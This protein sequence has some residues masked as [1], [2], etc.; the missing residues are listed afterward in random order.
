[1]CKTH[2]YS[3]SVEQVFH[4]KPWLTSSARST[5]CGSLDTGVFVLV[6]HQVSGTWK[7]ATGFPISANKKIQKKK[8]QKTNQVRVPNILR[9]FWNVT[10]CVLI[11]VSATDGG[12]PVYPRADVVVKAR[13]NW[14]WIALKCNL[15]ASW[16]D[17]GLASNKSSH[18]LLYSPDL[19]KQ[20]TTTKKHLISSIY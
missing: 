6:L 2:L 20:T 10:K 3:Y 1:M 17:Y 14:R 15:T 12:L 18:C 9:N 19:I 8:V 13:R 11:N 4:M 5:L 7:S 16:I